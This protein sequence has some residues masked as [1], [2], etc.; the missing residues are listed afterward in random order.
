MN[1]AAVLRVGDGRG[2]VV[3]RLNYLGLEERVVITAA[4]CLRR[5]PRSHQ[6]RYLH[7]CTWRLLGLLD[8]KRPTVWA[9]VLYLDPMA[10]IAVLGSPDNQDLSDEAEA[11]KELTNSVG[12]PFSIADAPAQVRATEL[13]P[14]GVV[15]LDGRPVE[16]EPH[17]VPIMKP[18]EASV[19][20]LSLSGEWVAA[21]V[22]RRGSWLS[23]E[24]SNL[25][26]G[27]MSGSP[28]VAD[29]A[30]IGLMSVDRLSPV[31]TDSLSVWLWRSLLAAQQNNEVATRC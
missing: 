12:E 25:L 28:I 15:T 8:R 23:I 29:G 1:A 9:E 11:Y 13:L 7:E 10:D 18:G 6:A 21:R 27:G 3:R 2:F 20:L 17:Q 4:H 19:S 16:I 14:G 26:V 30:A 5:L 31:L 24:P 22:E